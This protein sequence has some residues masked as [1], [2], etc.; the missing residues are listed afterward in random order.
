MAR[1]IITCIGSAWA[2][3]SAMNRAYATIRL[4]EPK[5]KD[6]KARIRER[7]STRAI[8]V[9]MNAL[10]FGFSSMRRPKRVMSCGGSGAETLM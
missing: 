4:C 2:T 9:R 3:G 10:K 7:V 5:F 1:K 6:H 8:S